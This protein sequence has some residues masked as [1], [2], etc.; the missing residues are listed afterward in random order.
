[1]EGPFL[2]Q[3]HNAPVHKARAIH[4]WF[5]EIGVKELDWPA[6]NPDFNAIKQLWDEL[7]LRLRARPNRPTPVPDLTNVRG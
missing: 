1:M 6:Q 3:H 5:V 7:E 4:K 2:F